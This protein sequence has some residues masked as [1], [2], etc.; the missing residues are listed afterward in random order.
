MKDKEKVGHNKQFEIIDNENQEPKS[1][2]K[3]EAKT[4]KHNEIQKPAWIKLNKNDFDSLR[5]HVCNNLNNGKL[6][7]TLDKK[8]YDLKNERRVLVKITTQNIRL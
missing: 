8:A 5:Q 7:T 6:K 2:K 4:K 1:S 3:E